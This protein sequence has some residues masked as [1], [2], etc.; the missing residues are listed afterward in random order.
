M[1]DVLIGD[2]KELRFSFKD[3]LLSIEN[4]AE[5]TGHFVYISTEECEALIKFIQEVKEVTKGY[6]ENN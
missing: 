4:G 3:N 5:M 1:E 2:L 6:E